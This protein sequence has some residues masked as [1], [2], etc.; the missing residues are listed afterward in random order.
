MMGC[1]ES[2]GSYDIANLTSRG[3]YDRNVLEN[4]TILKHS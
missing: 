4:V 1:M 3:V 2:L